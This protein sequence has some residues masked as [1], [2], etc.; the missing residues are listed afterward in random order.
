VKIEVVTT[1][2]NKQPYHARI[3]GDNGEIV[4][5]T[6]SYARKFDAVHAITELAAA[7]GYPGSAFVMDQGSPSSAN[8]M[9][10]LGYEPGTHVLRGISFTE[11]K[12]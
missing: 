8:G 2:D 3:K 4:W 12:E 9:L 1:E 7:F 11:V 6:E 10:Q 5:W